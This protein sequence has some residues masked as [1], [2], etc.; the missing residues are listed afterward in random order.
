MPTTINPTNDFNTPL[1][2][3]NSSALLGLN[4][5]HTT[6]VYK[7]TTTSSSNLNIA[8]QSLTGNADIKLYK[9]SAANEITASLASGSG[10][11]GATLAESL[12]KNSLD[13]GTYYVQVALANPAAASDYTLSVTTSQTDVPQHIFWRNETNPYP[14]AGW[15]LNGSTLA[16]ASS[17]ADLSLGPDWK[18]VGS[19]DFNGDGNDDLV[20]VNKGTSA[21]NG[22]ISIWLTN[23]YTYQPGSDVVRGGQ[24]LST[25]APISLPSSSGWEIK[26]IADF[27]G[28]GK[29]DLLWYNAQTGEGS[30]WVMNGAKYSPTE[31]STLPKV[32]IGWIVESVADFNGDSKADIFWRNPLTGEAS[33][34]VMDGAKYDPTLTGTGFITNPG[35][36]W[37]LVGTGDFNGDGKADLV[38]RNTVTSQTS[39]WLMDAGLT[40]PLTSKA[41]RTLPGTKILELADPSWT[42]AG[43]GD[44]N[45][46]KKSDLFWRNSVTNK[47]SVW[48]MDGTDYVIAPA[49]TPT[50]TAEL[51]YTLDASYQLLVKNQNAN[52]SLK[53]NQLALV[54]FNNDGNADLFWRNLNTGS[55]DIWT[56]NGGGPLGADSG[57]INYAGSGN[58]KL[59]K[60]W[61]NAAFLATKNTK[62]AAQSTA[63]TSKDAAFKIGTL[64]GDGSASY[65]DNVGAAANPALGTFA[66]P[67]DDYTFTLTS[68]YLLGFNATS[69]SSTTPAAV[70]TTLYL[71]GPVNPTTGK[72]T[73][74]VTTLTK[75]VPIGPGT[76]I[77]EVTP[78]GT[79]AVDYKL[80]IDLAEPVVE[81]SGVAS[82][83]SVDYQGKTEITLADIG[84]GPTSATTS[85]ILNYKIQN[86]GNYAASNVDVAF[87]LSRDGVITP[88]SKT[89]LNTTDKYLGVFTIP[90]IT[91]GSN[92]P[93]VG[94]V[95]LSLP[96]GDDDFWA[97]DGTYEIGMVINPVNDPNRPNYV[98]KKEVN[99]TNNFNIADGQ[100][101]SA[102]LIKNVQKPDLVGNAVSPSGT[103]TSG[104]PTTLNYTLANIGKKSTDVNF[105]VTI[106]F[107]EGSAPVNAS[108]FNRSAPNV[109]KL[110]D[111]T[112]T[113]LN[114]LGKL[115]TP[116]STGTGS[117]QVTISSVAGSQGYLVL[118][119]DSGLSQVDETLEDN[120]VFVG[121]L[122][123]I[124]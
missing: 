91:A 61:Q 48:V 8:L 38:W 118:E 121:S 84:S 123:T 32:P 25:D 34:W 100:D 69:P 19:G 47:L 93:Y 28:D 58:I 88:N 92:S 110:K 26:A 14:L 63:G 4:S 33:L 72:P 124:A 78:S 101:K 52:F 59:G 104:Q 3:P 116:T 24:Q 27:S 54:D 12:V 96:A 6:D 31:T 83:F 2:L 53:N 22:Q 80:N 35:S 23:G 36:N 37:K 42:I 73:Y 60:E 11:N 65:V 89:P 117:T 51:P 98:A 75:D 21:E 20:W 41:T 107:V 44:T 18:A 111:E 43:I 46:D 105:G 102:L 103:V 74:T 62:P 112:Y 95:T 13:A 106:Y 113:N 9:D 16:A 86:T 68:D 77:I 82:G 56:L 40:N 30:V 97:K 66:N 79:S 108:T 7:F 57:P 5:T 10:K 39:M 115:N 109:T 50:K 120:N 90:K 29:S 99:L 45:G 64:V 71:V 17:P 119:V 49:G 1:T 67:T 94:S 114:G 76:Y 122:I 55:L 15:G 87:Y 85:V 81:L 70:N